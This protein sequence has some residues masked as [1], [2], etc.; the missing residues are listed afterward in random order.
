MKQIIKKNI[1]GML[2]ILSENIQRLKTSRIHHVISDILYELRVGNRLFD[3]NHRVVGHEEKYCV[4]LIIGMLSASQ[5]IIIDEQEKEEIS[6][7]IMDRIMF[8]MYVDRKVDFTV[9]GLFMFTI[10]CALLADLYSYDDIR[11]I[12]NTKRVVVT[13]AIFIE[14]AEVLRVG[15]EL[16]KK[17]TNKLFLPKNIVQIIVANVMNRTLDM[18]KSFGNKNISIHNNFK[19]GTSVSEYIK[20]YMVDL[21]CENVLKIGNSKES[22]FCYKFLWVSLR[23]FLEREYV[24]WGQVSNLN[25]TNTFE[26]Q[27]IYSACILMNKNIRENGKQN[28][29][30]KV[31]RMIKVVLGFKSPNSI[32]DY[33]EQ[34][35]DCAEEL[36]IGLME[37]CPHISMSQLSDNCYEYK[38]NNTGIHILHNTS[39][40]KFKTTKNQKRNIRIPIS[41]FDIMQNKK[42][43]L[44]KNIDVLDPHYAVI[45]EYRKEIL[46]S[47][48]HIL[49]SVWGQGTQT[50]KICC[51]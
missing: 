39:D 6:K 13:Y 14:Y 51:M 46:I 20:A 26:Y 4:D 30:F 37:I 10:R 41:I 19:Y 24:H 31:Q 40:T 9:I 33:H 43:M 38:Q 49:I 12:C 25:K 8:K 21:L 47:F 11:H 2:C 5:V 48:V 45:L 1:K 42:K 28:V 29:R 15:C 27:E 35:V 22:S 3:K 18:I 32:E 23:L 7:S 36:K 16:E 44:S 34:S 50:N 17:L